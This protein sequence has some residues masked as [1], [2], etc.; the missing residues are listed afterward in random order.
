[1]FKI[2]DE[3]CSEISFRSGER[4]DGCSWLLLHVSFITHAKAAILMRVLT[5]VGST[6]FDALVNAVLSEPVLR[7]LRLQ[8]YS[9][10]VIQSGNSE[11]DVECTGDTTTLHRDGLDIE[12]WKFKPSLE[13]E[14]ESADLVI[15]HAGMFN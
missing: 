4:R 2:L 15:S 12:I 5:T 7:A 9:T 1:M 6:K 11:V 10:L 13:D 14:F 3:Q 8:G